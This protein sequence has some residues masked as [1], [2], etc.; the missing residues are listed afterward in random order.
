MADVNSAATVKG[1]NGKYT[2]WLVRRDLKM[3]CV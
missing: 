3:L 2:I 1:V